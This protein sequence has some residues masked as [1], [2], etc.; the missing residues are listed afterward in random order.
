MIL[1]RSATR[2]RAS[3]AS[4]PAALYPSR[5]GVLLAPTCGYL[6]HFLWLFQPRTC[7][8]V[9]LLK[10]DVWV[11][12]RVTSLSA[13]LLAPQLEF[14]LRQ[15]LQPRMSRSVDCS[16]SCL[17]LCL[18]CV[19][20][21]VCGVCACVCARVAR[22]CQDLLITVRRVYVYVCASSHTCMRRYGLVS[23]TSPCC[24]RACSCASLP[25]HMLLT[26]W[27]ARLELADPGVCSRCTRNSTGHRATLQ[28][29][30]RRLQGVLPSHVVRAGMHDAHERLAPGRLPGFLLSPFRACH[31]L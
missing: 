28:L 9:V 11:G 6:R 24:S 29:L 7:P 2:S 25:P 3:S 22:A 18:V 16:A 13:C 4:Y 26:Q 23:C 27:L 21:Y 19:C 5:V 12:E 20:V 8:A 10:G 1:Y 17:C 31:A 15:R 14:I 30:A